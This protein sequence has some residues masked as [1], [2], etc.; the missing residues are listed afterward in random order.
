VTKPSNRRKIGLD[1]MKAPE[2]LF[3]EREPRPA[4]LSLQTAADIIFDYM[5]RCFA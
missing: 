4:E 2:I 3:A 5:A 1:T